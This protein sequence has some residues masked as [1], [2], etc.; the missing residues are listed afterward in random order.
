MVNPQPPSPSPKRG[1][2]AAVPALGKGALDSGQTASQLLARENKAM[3]A[4][5]VTTAEVTRGQP[6]TA[7]NRESSTGML[8]S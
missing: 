6:R 2:S 3:C 4:E 7:C 5:P 8:F 1:P